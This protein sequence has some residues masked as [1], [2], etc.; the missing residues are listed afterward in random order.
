MKCNE[1]Q[2]TFPEIFKEPKKYSAEMEHINNCKNCKSEFD[3][4]KIISSSISEI[5]DPIPLIVSRQNQQIINSKIE[6]QSFVNRMRIITSVA[7]VII[8]SLIST[9]IF[10]QR[11]KIDFYYDN[12]DINTIAYNESDA[13]IEFEL[14]DEEILDYLI[15][16]E[17][18]NNLD[19]IIE[20]NFTN[21]E[22]K[23]GS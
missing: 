19:E 5:N 4:F 12:S 22:Y 23:N 3:I 10:Q 11:D 8:I 16:S 18:K 20:E 6:R 21:L 7:A 17:T 14:S 13:V 1:V 2:L 9:I 15:S